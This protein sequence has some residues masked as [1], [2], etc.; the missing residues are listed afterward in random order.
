MHHLLTTG[1]EGA[2]RRSI[3]LLDLSAALAQQGRLEEAIHWGMEALKSLEQT[4]SPRVLQ[5][6]I[7]V[8]HLLQ[9]WRG[10][11]LLTPFTEHLAQLKASLSRGLP[12]SVAE[13]R[14]E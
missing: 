9:P 4:R 10:E 13:R 3:R 2:H 12:V 14:A 7:A 1:Q 11:S 6:A 8:E 5:R